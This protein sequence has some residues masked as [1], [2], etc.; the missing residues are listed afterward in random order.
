MVTKKILLFIVFG[1]LQLKTA[2]GNTVIAE[3][4]SVEQ[5]TSF[6]F[7]VE[8]VRKVDVSSEVSG[9][10]ELIG[11]HFGEKVSKGQVLFQINRN[12]VKPLLDKVEHEIT[13]LK[14]ELNRAQKSVDAG[15]VSD[16]QLNKLKS[17]LD[18]ALSERLVVVQE[19]AKTEIVAPFDGFI[20]K[21]ELQVG[22]VVNAGEPLLT[23]YDG[24]EF[25]YLDV[26]I[27]VRYANFLQVGQLLTATYHDDSINLEV[28]HISPGVDSENRLQSVRFLAEKRKLFVPGMQSTISLAIKKIQA[29]KLSANAILFD[30]NGPYV[31]VKNQECLEV[32]RIEFNYHDDE[33]VM[34]YAGIEQGQMIVNEGAIKALWG[35]P[36][37]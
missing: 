15:G 35:A 19:L 23:L 8:S 18:I 34:V 1:F 30:A 22:D 2:Y 7:Q 33:S 27:P 13:F 12:K 6:N 11:F 29:A 31:F 36:L 4:N 17:D 32:S 28:V 16:S 5:L 14:K 10:I 9:R 26:F 20:T 37:C 24:S 3:M 25:V 21:H